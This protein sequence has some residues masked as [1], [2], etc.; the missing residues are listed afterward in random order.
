MEIEV[1]LQGKHKITVSSSTPG[2]EPF[3]T[4]DR[5]LNLAEESI[6]T[7]PFESRN[8]PEPGP[9]FC[10]LQEKVTELF[11]CLSFVESS[12]PLVAQLVHYYEC[13][14]ESALQYITKPPSHSYEDVQEKAHSL[15]LNQTNEAD[16]YKRIIQR[17]IQEVPY[18]FAV[19]QKLGILPF[20]KSLDPKDLPFRL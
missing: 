6:C 1:S 16:C 12:S 17:I 4:T 8:N 14:L 9:L 10:S 19:E 13:E 2:S 7:H 15:A 3:V 20:I 11:R 18:F 5:F